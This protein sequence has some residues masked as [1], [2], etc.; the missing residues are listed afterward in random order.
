MQVLV[1]GE[2]SACFSGSK[3]QSLQRPMDFFSKASLRDWL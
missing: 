1:F 3:K 2:P